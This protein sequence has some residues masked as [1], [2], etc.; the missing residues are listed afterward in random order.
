M[1]SIAAFVEGVAKFIRHEVQ[2]LS[3]Q[4]KEIRL[5]PSPAPKIE[6]IAQLLRR[7]VHET[8]KRK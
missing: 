6:Q 3:L 4:E 1:R 2:T 8:E 5:T 7:K